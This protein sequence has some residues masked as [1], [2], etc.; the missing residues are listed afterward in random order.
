M[1]M[2]ISLAVCDIMVFGIRG[3]LILGLPQVPVFL[4]LLP[5]AGLGES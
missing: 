1:L 2:E 4:T 3:T 5:T